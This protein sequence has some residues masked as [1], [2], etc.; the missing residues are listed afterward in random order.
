M[1][2]M[3]IDV[4]HHDIVGSASPITGVVEVLCGGGAQNQQ[5]L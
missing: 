1:G 5:E 4:A 3:T 2:G